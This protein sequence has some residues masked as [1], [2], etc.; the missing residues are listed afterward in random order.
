MGIEL[1]ALRG[2]AFRMRGGIWT[3]IALVVL[4]RIRPGEGFPL[5]GILVVLT[6]QALRFWA[7]GIIEGY[8]SEKVNAGFLVT[9]GPFAL[10]RNP[11][12]LGNGLIG[13][14]WGLMGGMEAAFIFCVAFVILYGLLIIPYE[15]EFLEERFGTAYIEYK[16]RTPRILPCKMPERG[17]LGGPFDRG[18]LWK[19]ERH[20]VYVTLAG[21]MIFLLRTRGVF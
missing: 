16:L 6:G 5:F 14:G 11:L 18:R 7:A 2:W 19:S 4:S 20:S 3:V 1:G 10:V 15:E 17:E 13:L 9:W 21:T 12:Y 8:R